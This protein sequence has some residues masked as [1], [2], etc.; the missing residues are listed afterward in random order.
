MPVFAMLRGLTAVGAR[1]GAAPLLAAILLG[2]A[3]TRAAAAT[4][5]VSVTGVGTASPVLR[6]VGPATWQTTVLVSDV[7]S[8]CAQATTV[9]YWLATRPYGVFSGAGVPGRTGTVAGTGPGGSACEVT[10]TFSKLAQVPTMAAL[11]ID[12]SGASASVT[13]TVSRDVTLA[14][15]LGEPAIA[16]GIAAGLYVLLLLF[17]T[18]YDWQ[19]GKHHLV[20]KAWWRHPVTG[21]GA[22]TVGDSWA[23]NISTG[24]VLV[25]TFLA[26]TTASSSLFPGV[27]LDRFA[28]VNIV[29]G[30]FV[31][32][33]PVLFAI[34]YAFFTNR[35]PGP[36]ADSVVKLPPGEQ[37]VLRVPSGATM[38]MVAPTAVSGGPP[39]S[40]GSVD[41]G[42]SYQ[43]S[44]ASV[45]AITP[46]AAAGGAAEPAA[47]KAI[48]FSG[49]S[50]IGV[51]PDATV[52]IGPDGA[53]P[54]VAASLP[55]IINPTGG[56]KIT[57]TGTADVHLPDHAVISGPRRAD[58]R[59]PHTDRWLLLPQGS[60]VI[61]GSLGIIVAANILTVFGI[62]AEL[63]IAFILAGFSDATGGWGDGIYAGLAALAG[64][65]LWYAI[66]ATRAIANP[67][68]GSALSAQAGTSFTL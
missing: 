31:V 6:Q 21:L 49:T 36:S 41:A 48:A 52:R 59:R 2:G 63:G 19:G 8:G 26:A 7:A 17:V 35:D 1:W 38:T 43:I 32:A 29:A 50:D 14:S 11:V 25:G 15:Y 13:L 66:S 30:V 62:G 65:V 28:I 57:V 40:P 18:T 39:G 33:A 67:Q 34:L 61:V 53:D 16:G 12:E 42:G 60:S 58:S 46:V 47:V 55:I 20:D 45:I 10:V 3:G 22:W 68:P 5:P 9:Q 54:A 51:L 24:L 37:V 64:F 27:A 23:T 4:P 56:A 44:P